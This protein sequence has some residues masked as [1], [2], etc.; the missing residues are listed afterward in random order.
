MRVTINPLT[1]MATSLS[2]S[3]KK[4]KDIQDAMKKEK[5]IKIY[6]RLQAV[7]WKNLKKPHQEIAFLLQVNQNTITNWFHLY[8]KK[9]LSGLCTLDYEGRRPSKLN[10][11]EQEIRAYIEKENISNIT[12]LQSWI[13]SQFGLHVEESWLYRYCKKNSIFP[14]RKRDLS[15]ENRRQKNFKKLPL[16]PSS[17]Q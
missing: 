2:F 9:G 6:R 7:L 12:I 16:S 5:N 17:K 3:K 13:E 15:R 10:R 4:L 14:I 1:F 8:E 11:Y